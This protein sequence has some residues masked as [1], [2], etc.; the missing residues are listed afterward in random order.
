MRKDK[1]DSRKSVYGDGTWTKPHPTP[2]RGPNTRDGRS[3]W[4]RASRPLPEPCNGRRNHEWVFD[5]P[6]IVWWEPPVSS[7]SCQFSD[8]DKRVCTRESSHMD[9]EQ[10]ISLESHRPPPGMMILIPPTASY[11]VTPLILQHWEGSSASIQTNPLN[12]TL[13]IN[14]LKCGFRIGYQYDCHIRFSASTNMMSAERNPAPVE[15]YMA[16]ELAAGCL[17]SL[18]TVTESK[19]N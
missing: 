3:L 17:C 16:M 19:T 13:L 5:P 7:T 11:I 18:I 15:E 6:L 4:C 2:R 9:M 1:I 10:L 14:G 12:R 8:I